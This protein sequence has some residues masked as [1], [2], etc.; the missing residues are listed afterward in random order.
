MSQHP[1]E[2]I[3]LYIKEPIASE[4]RKHC[5]DQRLSLSEFAA[6][7]LS[8]HLNKTRIAADLRDKRK[9]A[10]QMTAGEALQAR[11]LAKAAR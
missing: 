3:T 5:Y 7:A 9:L 6:D 10:K 2:R 1:P 4:F 8:I 11:K